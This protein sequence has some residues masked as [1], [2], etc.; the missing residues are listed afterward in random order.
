MQ[1]KLLTNLLQKNNVYRQEV[2]KM[3]N[4]F[5]EIKLFQV[6]PDKLSEFEAL[7][8]IMSKDQKKQKGVITIKY[9]KRFFTIDGVELGDPPRELTKIVKCVKYYSYWEFDNKENYGKAIEWFF[10]TYGKEVQKLLIMPF[11]INCGNIV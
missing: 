3:E 9:L 10:N 1:A 6:K 4:T 11:D 8:K 7:I 2:I 5:S